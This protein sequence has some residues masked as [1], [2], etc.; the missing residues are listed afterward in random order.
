MELESRVASL[1][2]RNAELE[3]RVGD[4]EGRLQR[5][6]E[7]ASSSE[8]AAEDALRMVGHSG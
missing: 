5:Q 8:R 2:S 7:A 4:L 1:T 3:E 6:T